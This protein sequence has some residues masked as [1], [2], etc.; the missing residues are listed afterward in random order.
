MSDNINESEHDLY[1]NLQQNAEK[2]EEN[3]KQDSYVEIRV[4]LPEKVTQIKIT[5]LATSQKEHIPA[6]KTTPLKITQGRGYFIP[7]DSN[8]DSDQY[9]YCKVFNDVSAVMV[10]C[11]V[12]DGY[13][14]VIA[15]QNFAIIKDEQLLCVYFN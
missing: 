13:A 15:L 10:I 3:P 9:K 4:K 1:S 2:L 11:Y 14:Y 12:K 5:N 8:I 7:I 6:V